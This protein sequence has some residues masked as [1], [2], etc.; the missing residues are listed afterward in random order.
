MRGLVEGRAV[1][2][3]LALDDGARYAWRTDT[4]RGCGECTRIS[5]AP[6]S[7]Y[8]KEQSGFS[9]QY[10]IT[11][12]YSQTEGNHEDVQKKKLGVV[13]FLVLGQG[14]GFPFST[15]LRAGMVMK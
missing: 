14:G 1:V 12:C 13:D 10:D 4:S 8:G 3:L 6:D 9:R 5:R 7:C 11:L 15:V 2:G